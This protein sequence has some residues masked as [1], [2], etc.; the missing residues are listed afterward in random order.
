MTLLLQFTHVYTFTTQETFIVLERSPL[1]ESSCW[2]RSG[3]PKGLYAKINVERYHSNKC[4]SLRH[5]KKWSGAGY[6]HKT[7]RKVVTGCCFVTQQ[8]I[9]SY[10]TPRHQHHSDTVLGSFQVPCPQ[11]RS[12]A[13][14]FWTIW[15]HKNALRGYRFVDD[16]VKRA[17]Y[18]W[19]HNQLKNFFQRHYEACRLL[20]LV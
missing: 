4:K 14:Q 2:Q 11:C 15:T 16:E 7:E 18:E 1:P 5:A 3:T 9:P 17:L 8:Y 20:G 10:G 12:G 13:F 19:L 6:L